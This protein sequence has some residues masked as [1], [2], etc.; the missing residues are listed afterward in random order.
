MHSTRQS[1]GVWSE[2]PG[3]QTNRSSVC[4]SNQQYPPCGPPHGADVAVG[5]G[6]LVAVGLLVVVGLTVGVTVGVLVGDTVGVEVGVKV[7]LDVG[8]RVGL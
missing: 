2:R 3:S 4:R 7:G 1:S 6:V 5:D 8:V